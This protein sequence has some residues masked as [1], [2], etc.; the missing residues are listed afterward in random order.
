M[1]FEL[2]FRV[3]MPDGIALHSVID[4]MRLAARLKGAV[5]Y[6]TTSVAVGEEGATK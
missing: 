3:N 5:I 4:A 2:R 6:A 1:E